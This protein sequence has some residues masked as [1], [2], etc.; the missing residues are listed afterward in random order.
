M[1]KRLVKLN[2]ILQQPR[3][4]SAGAQLTYHTGRMP[5]AARGQLTFFDQHHITDPLLGQVIG[6]RAT[7]DTAADHDHL[8][9]RGLWGGIHTGS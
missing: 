4:I 5:R 3:N 2:R 9:L 1:G 8:R 7:G 6:G